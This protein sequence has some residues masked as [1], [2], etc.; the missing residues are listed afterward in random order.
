MGKKIRLMFI[1]VACLFIFIIILGYVLVTPYKIRRT[2][3]KISASDVEKVFAW[4]S[5]NIN[6]NLLENNK[7][8]LNKI[9]EWYNESRELKNDGGTTPDS[10][11]EIYLKD[12]SK[13]TI[14]T[15]YSK[16]WV[17][18]VYKNKNGYYYQTNASS[19]D[20]AGFIEGLRKAAGLD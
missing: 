5:R 12:K 8:D 6:K 4:E 20:L 9:V 14:L 13:I 1:G 18:I 11:V 10:A 16:E 19:S 15:L 17:T 7:Y 2:L 3:P